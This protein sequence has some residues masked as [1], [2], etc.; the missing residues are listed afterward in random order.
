MSRELGKSERGEVSV[1]QSDFQRWCVR[2]VPRSIG[3]TRRF[4]GVL[5]SDAA[6][7]EFSISRGSSFPRFPDHRPKSASEPFLQ[8]VEHFRC[9]T[10]SEVAD[11]SAEIFREVMDHTGEADT[12]RP[13][14]E[15]PNSLL[16]PCHR[17]RREAPL[18]PLVVR[19]AES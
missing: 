3:A 19:E 9:F 16:E 7:A 4:R 2:K 17:F 11:P 14:C 6:L 8:L 18:R 15:F 5:R 10:S 12:P 13:A 1:G